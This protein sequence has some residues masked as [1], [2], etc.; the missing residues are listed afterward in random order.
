[1]RDVLSVEDMLGLLD[2]Q[3]KQIAKFRGEV[4]NLGGGAANSVSLREAT[5]AMQKISSRTAPV[6]QTD[7]ARQGDIALYWTDN[8]KAA[9]QLGWKPKTDLRTGFVHIFDWIREN[10][11]ELRSRDVS[12]N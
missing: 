9:E 1:M 11:A 12:S 6:T 7:K 3:I 5:T 2:L 10:E 8:R 4:F